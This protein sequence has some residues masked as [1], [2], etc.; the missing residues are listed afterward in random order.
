MNRIRVH[1]QDNDSGMRSSLTEYARGLSTIQYRHRVIHEDDIRA[2]F[3]RLAYRLTAVLNTA[4]NFHIRLRL[5]H[6][7]QPFR[8]YGVIVGDENPDGHVSRASEQRS[9]CRA[10]ALR[11]HRD[12]P[13]PHAPAPSL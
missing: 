3:N 4:D 6:M 5:D 10:L 7:A 13:P 11:G 2:V 8:H 12:F 1:R 9:W